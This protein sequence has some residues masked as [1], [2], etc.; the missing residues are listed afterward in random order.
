VRIDYRIFT[1]M[2]CLVLILPILI[3][4]GAQSVYG[5]V[6]QTNLNTALFLKYIPFF[7]MFHIEK[8]AGYSIDRITWT[9]DNDACNGVNGP[10]G[11]GG[12]NSTAS[13]NGNDDNGGVGICQLGNGGDANVESSLD[14][15]A[16]NGGNDFEC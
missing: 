3:V 8:Y 10:N 4:F 5:L 9:Q 11:L 13:L 1:I 2:L 12:I 16:C 6:L 15:S 7:I 14:H